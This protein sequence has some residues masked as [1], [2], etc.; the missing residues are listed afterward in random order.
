MRVKEKE[1]ISGLLLL[2]FFG[3][4]IIGLSSSSGPQFLH[5]VPYVFLISVVVIIGNNKYQN[6]DH[7]FFYTM[8]FILSFAI[9]FMLDLFNINILHPNYSTTL[10]ISIIGIPLII[11]IIWV[12]VINSVNGILRKFRMNT[13]LATF[14]GAF[15]VLVLDV[16][17][18]AQAVKFGFW[19]WEGEEI[20]VANYFW[21]FSLSFGFLL[22]S[23]KLNIRNNTFIGTTTYILLLLFFAAADA[24]TF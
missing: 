6:F 16:F 20:P 19:N 1:Y 11:P 17:L 4:T 5:L 15:L 7:Y 22:A 23:F 10:G 14:L 18:E 2:A 3:M 24:I 12:I 8:I 9:H 13:I 21:W